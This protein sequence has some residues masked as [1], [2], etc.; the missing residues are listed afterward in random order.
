MDRFHVSATGLSIN[1]LPEY[2]ARELGFFKDVGIEETSEVPTDWTQVLRDVDSGH[3]QAALGGIW[4]PSIYKQHGIKDYFAFAK[5]SCRCPMELVA[6][7]KGEKAVSKPE[8]SEGFDWRV[9]ENKQILCPGGN[10]VS[11]YM[12]LEGC[13][14]EHGVDMNTVRWV[15]DFS[16]GMLLEGFR[17][18]WGDVIVL[19]PH[20]AATLYESGKGYLLCE[21][22]KWGGAV[23]WSVYYGLPE[24]IE[25]KDDLA[26]RFTFALQRGVDWLL[27][28]DA[29]DCA[30]LLKRNWPNVGVEVLVEKVN[31]LRALGM[32]SEAVSIGEEEFTHYEE[33][34]VHTGIIDKPLSWLQMVDPRPF[35]YAKLRM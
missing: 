12:F 21:L 4:V 28:H 7:E 17:T 8:Q 35:E 5:V 1:Y 32:W 20:M 10:G 24:L 15:H 16:A 23:P 13:M 14:R 11:T 34:M 18:D 22:A 25:R 27:E 6:R 2:I 9:L 3:A 33:Y 19:P 26:G 30:D 29:K 31:R